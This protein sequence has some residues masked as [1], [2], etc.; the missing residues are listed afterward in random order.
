MNRY[1]IKLP[2]SEADQLRLKAGDR[3]LLTGGLYTARDAAHK[4][5]SEA[6]EQ[7][8]SCQYKWKERRFIMLVRPRPNL[9][10]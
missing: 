2:L 8:K 4:R 10:Q 5:M 1:Q 9:G 7:K 6:I 3:V